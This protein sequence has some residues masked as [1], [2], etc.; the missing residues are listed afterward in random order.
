M[1]LNIY[2]TPPEVNQLDCVEV[3]LPKRLKHL[4]ELYAYL[5]AKVTDRLGA[6]VLDGFSIYEVDGVFH[7]EEKLWEERSLAIPILSPRSAEAPRAV[8]DARIRALC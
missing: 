1:L 8:S 2:E 7:G 3:Y 5:R 6:I 4:S